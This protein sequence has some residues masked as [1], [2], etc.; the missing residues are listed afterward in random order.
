MRDIFRKYKSVIR[1]VALFLGSYTILG[2]LYF[3]YLKYGT[4]TVYFPD[5]LTNLVARQSA[6]VLESFGYNV[7]LVKDTLE[8]GMLLTIDGAYTVN[9]VEGC[10]S[11][12]VIILFVAFIIAFAEKFKK[13]F[14]FV[15]AGA[16][17]IYV[18]NIF[19]I[20]LLTVALHKY[21]HYENVLH[22][23]VFPGIIYGMVFI[24]WILWVRMLK[25][26][27]SE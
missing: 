17:M 9:I 4:S 11:V 5:Y 20:V 21:P 19:R 24:L 27:S 2:F 3:T 1:F 18:V 22:L 6:S 8:K 7:V 16:V 13:T 26:T 10:N 12:S 14:L 15:L 25:P 23:V